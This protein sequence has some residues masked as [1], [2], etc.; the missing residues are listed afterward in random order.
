MPRSKLDISKKSRGSAK[1][2]QSIQSLNRL[3]IV[4]HCSVYTVTSDVMSHK[5][6][7]KAKYKV[8]DDTYTI[9]DIFFIFS[10]PMK[11]TKPITETACFN[12]ERDENNQ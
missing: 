11:E 4:A 5:Q 12:K 6:F 10:Y 7:G 8:F 3:F 9:Q 2:R 1:D